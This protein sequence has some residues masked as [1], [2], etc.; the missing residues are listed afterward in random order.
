MTYTLNPAILGL[1]GKN[2]WLPEL[3]HVV[4]PKSIRKKTHSHANHQFVIWWRW[5]LQMFLSIKRNAK[6]IVKTIISFIC[7]KISVNCLCNALQ[8]FE[9]FMKIPNTMWL[10]FFFCKMNSTSLAFLYKVD[11]ETLDGFLDS[12]VGVN[13][14]K[15]YVSKI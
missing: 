10:S 1:F 5:R 3:D 11:L 13:S 7:Y 4:P 12:P 14:Q 8:V 9:F 6:T 2:Y 15:N